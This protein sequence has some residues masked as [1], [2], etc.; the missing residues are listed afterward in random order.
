MSKYLGKPRHSSYITAGAV[1]SHLINSGNQMIQF[2][3]FSPHTA[4]Q[5]KSWTH[6]PPVHPAPGGKNRGLQ[7]NP[8]W[9]ANEASEAVSYE[10]CICN[11]CDILSCCQWGFIV[12]SGLSSIMVYCRCVFFGFVYVKISTE[13]QNL[14]KK[15]TE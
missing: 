11:A 9:G 12:N 4:V 3:T 2:P 6:L 5:I 13:S 7:N 8:S 10:K 14:F 1:T 15:I